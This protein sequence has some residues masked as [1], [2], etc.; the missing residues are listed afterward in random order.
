MFSSAPSMLSF[1]FLHALV[2]DD[3][4]SYSLPPRPPPAG[5]PVPATPQGDGGSHG[6]LIGVCICLTTN[7]LLQTADLYEGRGTRRGG[8]THSFDASL[9]LLVLSASFMRNCLD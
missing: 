7:W 8:G 9:L 5:T 4:H 2:W 1:M 3:M 6:N